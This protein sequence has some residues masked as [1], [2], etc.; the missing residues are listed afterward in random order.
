MTAH[1]FYKSLTWLSTSVLISNLGNGAGYALFNISYTQ[2][3][4][5]T[6]YTVLS[7]SG[8][9]TGEPLKFSIQPNQGLPSADVK[10]P[11]SIDLGAKKFGSN[12]SPRSY[13]F[14]FS[15]TF[16]DCA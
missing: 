1:F 10:L 11:S 6:L 13:T 8:S 5:P 15:V 4:V 7:G 3:K 9:S 12:E 16:D 2:P 14:W